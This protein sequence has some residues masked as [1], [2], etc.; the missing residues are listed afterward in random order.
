M[1]LCK[2]AVCSPSEL[3]ASQLGLSVAVHPQQQ[4]L[5]VMLVQAFLMERTWVLLVYLLF[6]AFIVVEHH[7]YILGL[8]DIC[9]NVTSRCAYPNIAMD[10]D[11]VMWSVLINKSL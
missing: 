7:T 2:L 4:D 10:D 3:K 9:S 1:V 6:T 11:I 8:G 5:G